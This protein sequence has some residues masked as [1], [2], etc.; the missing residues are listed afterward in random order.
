MKNPFETGEKKRHSHIVGEADLARF[1]QGLVHQVFSTFA[2]AREAEW[3]GR[4]F[5]LEMKD[6]DE[7]GIG[8]SVTV[9]HLSPALLGQKVE[10]ESEL[11]SVQ[12]N[13][14]RTSYVAR[15]GDREVA[16]GTQGQKILKKSR[17]AALFGAMESAPKG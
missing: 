11:V 1:E 8:T 17:L 12:G 3:S 10:F 16:R 4:L 9:E 15:V 13:E 5:V 6:E 14:V 2:L 7:E